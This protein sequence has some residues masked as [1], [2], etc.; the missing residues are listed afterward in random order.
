MPEKEEEQKSADKL[1]EKYLMGIGDINA[2]DKFTISLAVNDSGI[3]DVQLDWPDNSEEEEMSENIAHL[4]YALNSGD[5]KSVIVESLTE[6][7][8]KDPT[9]KKSVEMAI[10]KWLEFQN[11]Y[12]NEPCV[13]PREALGQ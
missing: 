4:L 1:V 11:K 13:K 9:L 6:G 10:E 12:K 5:L 7:P 8:I 3:V 2:P